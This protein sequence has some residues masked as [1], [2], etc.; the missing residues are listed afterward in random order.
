MEIIKAIFLGI[1]QGLT[2]F[3]PISSSGHLVLMQKLIGFS[4]PQLFFDTILH[5]G[6]LFAVVVVLWKDIWE[7]LKKPFQ[8]M[9]LLI[10]VATIP[11]AIMGLAFK[12]MIEKIFEG[13]K[14]LGVEFI[15]TGLILFFASRMKNGEKKIENTSNF[16]AFFIGVMQ[17]IAIL[18]AI[19]RSGLTIAGALFRKM[20][21]DF[22]A[23]F[24][25]LISIPAILGAVVI[26]S[27]DVLG[28]PLSNG[29]V[30]GAG[31]TFWPIFLGFVFAF[32]FGV[33]S[34][35]YMMKI[36]RKGNLNG[37]AIYVSI[38]G[39]LIIFDQIFTHV[40]F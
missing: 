12:D 29:N 11:T 8:K 1:V 28:A 36:I 37:F 30:D 21:R 24:S 25:F 13:G 7:L 5:L 39:A 33:L 35:R 26:Q 40:F 19:S 9:T 27:K 14:T 34:V 20:D 23:K 31:M 38:L 15:I 2:E 32:L 6:T 18:P 16:D 4:G 3:L 22:A 10:I 17:G